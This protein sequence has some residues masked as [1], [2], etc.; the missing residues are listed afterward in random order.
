MSSGQTLGVKAQRF[1]GHTSPHRNVKEIIIS[2]P[3]LQ[4]TVT[5]MN[6]CLIQ[7]L[8]GYNYMPCKQICATTINFQGRF[9]EEQ[10][11]RK[12]YDRTSKI[13][14]DKQEA[15][16]RQPSQKLGKDLVR[17][18]TPS[19][20]V[21]DRRTLENLTFKPASDFNIAFISRSFIAGLLTNWNVISQNI[22]RYQRF[23][24]I[25]EPIMQSKDIHIM[26]YD[27]LK[28][29]YQG[30]YD[31]LEYKRSKSRQQDDRNVKE[32]A[33][34]YMMVNEQRVKKIMRE[35]QKQ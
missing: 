26:R 9:Q 13:T 28:Y 17:I 11:R 15:G 7:Q 18:G 25:F 8:T 35:K 14:G 1:R 19:E 6:S 31:L 21:L 2:N 24:Q 4:K 5:M 27:K 20:E 3:C 32:Q 30:L 16:R 34:Q 12:Q 10:G 22:E 23:S 29:K 33:I